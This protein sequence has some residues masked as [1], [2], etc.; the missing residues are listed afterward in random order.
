MNEPGSYNYNRTA[1]FPDREGMSA[2]IRDGHEVFHT[3]SSYGRGID[4]FNTAY[5]YLD[6]TARGRDEGGRGQYWVRRHDEYGR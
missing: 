5:N 6:V 4:I 3:Y 1:E 2:F